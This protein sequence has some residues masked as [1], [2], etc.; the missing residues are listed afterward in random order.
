MEKSI[1]Q[2]YIDLKEGKISQ[3]N[4]MR[5]LR[6]TLPQYV[7]NVTSFDDSIKILKNK[8]IINETKL[9]ATQVNPTE[10]RMGV[11]IEME[12]TGDYKKAE[13]IALD[14]LSENPFYYT[15]L[16]LAGLDA[17]RIEKTPKKRN[18]IEIT[19]E[20]DNLVN[21]ANGM[22]PVKGV[23][24]IKASA[25]KAYKETNDGVKGVQELT[26]KSKRAKG[27]KGTMD[28]TGGK[29][30]KV[31]LKENSDYME[32]LRAVIRKELKEA[33]STEFLNSTNE[34]KAGSL[35][36]NDEITLIDSLG[37][38]IKGEKVTIVSIKPYGGDL[39][40]MLSNGKDTDDFYVDKN[41][42]L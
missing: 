7:T 2:Q 20:K 5:N 41:D 13:K 32:R 21:T 1:K 22:K 14:H 30:K 37:K 11:K 35:S 12:H 34:A 27:I 23:E 25:N 8:G 10:L 31:T 26:H 38:F 40:I 33:L 24:K 6:L 3:V 19:V 16:H 18:D 28:M 15:H 39:Q 9:T 17:S 42:E 36:V 4:F 29:M